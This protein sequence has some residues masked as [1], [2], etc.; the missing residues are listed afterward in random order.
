VVSPGASHTYAWDDTFSIHLRVT[1]ST[2]RFADV[3]HT[4]TVQSPPSGPTAAFV[5]V[6]CSG[7]TCNVDAS[8]STGSITNYHWDWGDETV[9][10]AVVPTASHTYAWDDT[11][12]I[13]LRVTDSTGQFGDVTHTVTVRLPPSGPTASFTFTCSGRNCSFNGSTSSSSVP[14]VGYHWEWDDETTTDTGGPLANHLYRRR[15][16]FQVHLAVTDANGAIGRVTGAVTV[17]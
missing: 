6:D 13:H 2:G 16:T 7:R 3:T 12:S 11:F 4:V 14:I 15:G 1:D 8:G 5:V 10:D 9:S 17:R